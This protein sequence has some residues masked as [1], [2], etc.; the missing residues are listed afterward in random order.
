ML[1]HGG[2]PALGPAMQLSHP[3]PGPIGANGGRPGFRHYQLE[4][5][6]QPAP[7]DPAEFGELHCKLIADGERPVVRPASVAAPRV[8][9]GRAGDPGH[10]GVGDRLHQRSPGGKP[11][12]CVEIP[13]PAVAG[14]WVELCFNK[15]EE[16]QDG[17]ARRSL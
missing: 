8:L 16:N 1:H 11:G 14:D 12:R 5:M 4:G 9:R 15:Q 3:S 17:F 10:H 6:T 13:I 2:G 7:A